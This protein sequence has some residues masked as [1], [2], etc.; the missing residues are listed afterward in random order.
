MT[1]RRQISTIGSNLSTEALVTHRLSKGSILGPLHFTLYVNEVPLFVQLCHMSLSADDTAITVN[2]EEPET[3]QQEL[4]G[5]MNNVLL[6]YRRKCLAV[7]VVYSKF[8]L[9]GTSST[10]FSMDNIKVEVN[11]H[12]LE[13][14]TCYKSRGVKLDSQLNFHDHINYIKGRTLA[15][16][17][18]L[19]RIS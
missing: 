6:W 9:F 13:K 5:A 11:G 1:N 2:A 4:E 15:K 16:I 10:L 12:S 18:L 14:V 8:I 19:S 7:N 17:N 3:L